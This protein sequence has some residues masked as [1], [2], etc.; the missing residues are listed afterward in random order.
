[1]TL[2]RTRIAIAGFVRLSLAIHFWA[3]REHGSSRPRP[4]LKEGATAPELT[5]KDVD[6]R[7]VSMSDFRGKIVIL[8]FWA[9]WCQPCLAEFDLLGPWWER[10]K[11]AGVENDVVFV[12][13][14]VRESRDEVRRFLGHHPLPFTVLLDEQGQVADQYRVS[15]LPTLVLIGPDGLVVG[16]SEGYDPAVAAALA[17]QLKTM[18]EAGQTP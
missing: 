18:R 6:G 7:A 13:V 1:M 3:V 2:T 11:E 8:D 17:A 15:V 14:N 4:S 9:S 12:A 10:Q 5:L 16:Q